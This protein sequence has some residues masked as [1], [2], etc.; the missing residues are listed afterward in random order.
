MNSSHSVPEKVLLYTMQC[1]PHSEV[2]RNR[3]AMTEA[4][5][6]FMSNLDTNKH[7]SGKV[8]I[9]LSHL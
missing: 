2:A 5:N 4:D 6:C 3:W 8:L 9:P 1:F 7:S